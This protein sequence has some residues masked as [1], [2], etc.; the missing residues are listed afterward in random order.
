M[1]KFN[2]SS[3]SSCRP[4]DFGSPVPAALAKMEAEGL[5]PSDPLINYRSKAR[6]V[7]EQDKERETFPEHMC[8]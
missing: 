8:L 3:C 1:T 4:P 7:E 5:A 6:P 2:Q